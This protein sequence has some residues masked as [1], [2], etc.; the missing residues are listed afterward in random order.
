MPPDYAKFPLLPTAVSRR[1]ECHHDIIK[2]PSQFERA[3]SVSRARTLS[4][5]L[6]LSAIDEAARLP[7]ETSFS[8]GHHALHAAIF[9]HHAP[10]THT[11]SRRIFYR[12]R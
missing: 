2:S 8:N 4:D 6:F 5:F 7:F 9:R 1:A 10:F 12:G 11:I 3:T